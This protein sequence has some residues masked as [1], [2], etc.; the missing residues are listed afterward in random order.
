MALRDQERTGPRAPA[1]LGPCG[2][3][4]PPVRVPSCC[5][6]CGI[7]LD[8]GQLAPRAYVC[9]CGRHFPLHAGAWIAVLADRGS[10][11]ERWADLVPEDVPEWVEPTPYRDTMAAAAAGGVNEAVR[12]GGAR[13][14]G[15]PVWLAAFDLR[16]VGGSLGMVAGERLVRSM[17]HAAVAG[18]PLVIVTA[19]GGA[20]MQE[21]VN[22][23]MQMARVNAALCSVRE[24]RVPYFSVLAHPT[25]GGTAASLALLADIV[26]AEPGAAIGF[27]GPR[28]I[29]QATHEWLPEDFQTA[30]YQQRHGQ[31]DMIVPRTELRQ[32][33][34]RLVDLFL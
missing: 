7:V 31:V 11:E 27:T 5:P 14:G 34:A 1:D 2:D 20:R 9:G 4:P 6:T 24:A 17:A 3:V 28:V 13:I 16:C 18:V 30:E 19:S 33:L 12:C 29:Q 21:G 15:R 22:A 32:R 26:I 10:W 25:Y 8:A 23:L